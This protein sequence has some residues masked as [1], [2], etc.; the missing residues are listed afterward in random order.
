[1]LANAEKTTLNIIKAE[2]SNLNTL[3]EMINTEIAA[4]GQGIAH[5]WV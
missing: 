4:V 5:I 1:M 2:R 3:A